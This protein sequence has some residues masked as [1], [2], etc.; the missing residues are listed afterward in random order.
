MIIFKGS[1]KSTLSRQ[2]ISG[3][4]FWMCYRLNRWKFVTGLVKTLQ[5]FESEGKV[6]LILYNHE[7]YT[8]NEAVSFCKDHDVQPRGKTPRSTYVLQSFGRTFFKPLESHCTKTTRKGCTEFQQKLSI[9]IDFL[10]S[11]QNHTTKRRLLPYFF[12]AWC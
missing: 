2:T 1:E 3:Y 5:K 10:H 9:K 6:L 12:M 7:S 4:C 11:L 8:S